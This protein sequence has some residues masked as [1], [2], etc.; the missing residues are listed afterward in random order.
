MFKF[1]ALILKHK[2]EGSKKCG[3]FEIC[4]IDEKHTI[5]KLLHTLEV[6][7]IQIFADINLC[8]LLQSCLVHVQAGMDFLEKN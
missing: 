6:I 2:F 4:K 3:T 7:E 1:G 5:L 8:N